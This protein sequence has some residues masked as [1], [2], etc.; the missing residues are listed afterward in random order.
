MACTIMVR[1]QR[2]VEMEVAMEVANE[3]WQEVCVARGVLQWRCANGGGKI[4]VP[5]RIISGSSRAHLAHLKL[6]ERRVN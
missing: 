3:A 6:P 1:W 5:R 2:R 4:E